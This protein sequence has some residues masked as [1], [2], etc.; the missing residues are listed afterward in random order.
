VAD[1]TRDLLTGR[2]RL[3]ALKHLHSLHTERFYQRRLWEWRVTFTFWGG[4]ALAAT[5]LRG[6]GETISVWVFWIAYLGTIG[7]HFVWEQQWVYREA[8]KNRDLGIEINNEIE[9]MIGRSADE[10][11]KYNPVAHYWQVVVTA[12][13]GLVVY[14]TMYLASPN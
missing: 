9:A 11:N 3:D 12:L 8:K 2:D 14:A 5:A 4:L 10:P 7:L 1:N 6:L 13:L